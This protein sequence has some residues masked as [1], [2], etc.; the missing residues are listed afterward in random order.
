VS[1]V[2]FPEASDLT[3]PTEDNPTLVR[4]DEVEVEVSKVALKGIVVL[5]TDVTF[6]NEVV[7]EVSSVALAGM[8]VP[9]TVV[10][11]GS[12]VV[13]VVTRVADEGIVV[14]LILVAVAAPN[15]GV[16]KLGLTSGA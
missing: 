7:A 13:A 12:E 6:G 15:E 16:V 1:T 11:L 3:K 4:D 9:L 5:F 14:P 8:L 10:R 2:K